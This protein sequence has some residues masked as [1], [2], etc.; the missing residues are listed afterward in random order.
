MLWD[1]RGEV[2][3]EG[4]AVSASPLPFPVCIP[5]T[6]AAP[7]AWCP[8]QQLGSVWVCWLLLVNNEC[9]SKL[10][11][12]TGNLRT[13]LWDAPAADYRVVLVERP[14]HPG[15]PEVNSRALPNALMLG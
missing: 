12:V 13:K 4:E 15:R 2:S 11:A 3:P 1:S 10:P 7:C 14:P 8:E 5:D 6:S 9:P